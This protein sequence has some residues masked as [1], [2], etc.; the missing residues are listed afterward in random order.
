MTLRDE[1]W[2]IMLEQIVRTGK[3]KLGD[4][5]LKDSERHTARR[6][7]RQMQEYDWLTR[8]SP[9]AA[10]WRAGPK[11]EMLLNLSEDKLELARN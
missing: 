7:A 2:T 8:D 5:P 6:V 10:I 9:S 1:C 11:A 4:L 3:F